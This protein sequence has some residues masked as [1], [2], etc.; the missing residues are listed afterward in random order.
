MF[1]LSM[2]TVKTNYQLMW[3]IVSGTFLVYQVFF[4]SLYY[5]FLER[6]KTVLFYGL[7][8]V[9]LLLG[10]VLD[11]SLA[12]ILIR[13]QVVTNMTFYE[14]SVLLAN[15]FVMMSLTGL[16]F[17]EVE[18][19]HIKMIV[20]IVLSAPVI[21]IVSILLEQLV[22]W[23]LLYSLLTMGFCIYQLIFKLKGMDDTLK[24]I[25]LFYTIGS[26]TFTLVDKLGLVTSAQYNPMRLVGSL[27]SFFLILIYFMQ[28]YNV[29]QEKKDFLYERL[30]KDYLTGAY[31]KSYFLSQRKKVE[32]GSVMFI[33]INQFKWINDHLGHLVADKIL[34]DFSEKL[35]AIHE[36]NK[37]IIPARFGGDE[38]SIILKNYDLKSSKA[39]AQIVILAFKAALAN[40]TH[41]YNE[42]IG[43]S[44]GITTFDKGLSIDTLNQADLLMYKAKERGN[45]NIATEEELEVLHER[46]SN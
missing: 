3:L 6:S 44:V 4:A 37:D 22:I 45:Y 27:S 11:C 2:Y 24:K 40:Q 10:I 25:L 1:D 18:K 5:I 9:S 20:V 17:N 16:V 7:F 23:Y 43:I 41:D 32:K 28:R 13:D 34:I 39:F 30:K 31:S 8:L 26:L 21:F 38:F 36:E 15:Y 29:I 46:A 42:N 19:N 35:M 33:D 14:Y 12:I